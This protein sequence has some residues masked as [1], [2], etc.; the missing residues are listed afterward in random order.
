MPTDDTMTE[1]EREDLHRWMYRRLTA[2]ERV[3][4]AARPCVHELV[5][6]NAEYHHVTKP[7][8]IEALR[9]ALAALDRVE[10]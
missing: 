6:H 8:V 5:E 3:A 2:L 9:E 4:R 10:P 7:E 1:D